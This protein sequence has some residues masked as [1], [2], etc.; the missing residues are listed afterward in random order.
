MDERNHG[1]AFRYWLLTLLC[2][3][4]CQDFAKGMTAVDRFPKGRDHRT[5][6]VC[7]VMVQDGGQ[8]LPRDPGRT[9]PSGSTSSESGLDGSGI[10]KG[11]S[12]SKR[13]VG[14]ICSPPPDIRM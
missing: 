14:K 9:A 3:N 4:P 7:D 11:V 10:V 2:L 13:R 1:G 5:M 6:P 12:A 8:V